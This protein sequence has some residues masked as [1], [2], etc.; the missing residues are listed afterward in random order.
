[1]QIMAASKA[2]HCANTKVGTDENYRT[3]L[4]PFGDKKT[5]CL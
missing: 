3:F 5:S 4:L 2:H 1:M